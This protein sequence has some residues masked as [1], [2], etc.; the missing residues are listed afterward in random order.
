[1]AKRIEPPFVFGVRVEGGAFTDREIE[2]HRL[3]MNFLYG[4]NT[5]LV[6]PRRMG[7]T[8]LVDKVCAQVECESENVKIVRF[9]AFSC[10][11]EEDFV[12]KY[13]TAIVRATS[14]RLEEWVTTARTLLGR[15]VPK[16]SF[17]PDPMTDF[18]LSLEYNAANTITEDVLRMP[19]Q[20]AATKGWKIII[21]I[22]EFQQIGDFDNSLEF[23]KKLRSVWQLQKN[24]SYC[25]YGSKRHM[26]ENMFQS[27][28]NPF[29]RFGDMMYLGKISEA[30]WVKF[31]SERFEMTG[32]T[33]AEPLAQEICYVTDRYSSYVQQLAWHTWL[34][35]ATETTRTDLDAAINDLLDSCEP[36]FVQ[37]TERLSSYQMNFLRALTDG[38]NSG[39]SQKSIL[40]RYNLG[41]A[42]NVT[43][44]KRSMMEKDLIYSASANCIEISDPILALWLKKR[45]F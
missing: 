22:D 34:H 21:C 12:N 31:I 44:L 38:V 13:A 11:S 23:Q 7:K 14:G 5:I 16:I 1:M 20:I 6:S 42:A 9:D 43:K 26:M 17:G 24:V 2:T 41:T 27:Q 10:R 32:K 36:L 39:F 33:I 19:E 37:Q 30:D 28:S 45:V 8:S 35:T 15:F 4:V 40:Q 18:S 3:K 29:Y 25:L